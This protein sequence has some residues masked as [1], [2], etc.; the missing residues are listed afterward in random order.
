MKHKKTYIECDEFIK[1]TELNERGTDKF[2]NVVFKNFDL[3]KKGKKK[4]IID[5]F[6][7][8]KVIQGVKFNKWIIL[9]SEEE[10]KKM[11]EIK[12]YANAFGICFHSFVLLI[13]YDYLK[14]RKEI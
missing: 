9:K 7:I 4:L 3:I 1:Y 6:K 8:A 5:F 13:V 14:N 10:V 2:K 12:E 11:Q